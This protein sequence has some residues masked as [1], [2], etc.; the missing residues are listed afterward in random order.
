[1]PETQ[2]QDTVEQDKETATC[3][4]SPD[5]PPS[6]CD[7]GVSPSGK[8]ET[9]PPGIGVPPLDERYIVWLRLLSW[10]LI[11]QESTSPYAST[12]E[13]ALASDD[14]A[15][16]QDAANDD[17]SVA[18]GSVKMV[19]P[20]HCRLAP[21]AFL[22]MVAAGLV[23][24]GLLLLLLL[25]VAAPLL[26]PTATVTIIPRAETLTTATTVTVVTNGSP[27]VA[28][29]QV[30]GRR[31]AALTLSQARIVPTTG[32]GH[33]DA[34]VAHGTLILYNAL[35]T[36]QVIPAGTLL[37]G[38][39][40]V[41]VVTDQNAVIPAGSLS[42]NGWASVPAHAL[43]P[44]PAGNISADDIYGVCCR[45]DVFARNETPFTGGQNA[46]AFP[47]V[48]RQDID[49]AVSTPTTDLA[50]SVQ[51]AF[52]SQLAPDETLVT[53]VPCA[54][55][56]MADHAVGEEETQVTVTL[57]EQCTATA[58]QSRAMQALI[59]Q[60][61]TREASHQLGEDYALEGEIEVRVIAS[62]VKHQRQETIILQV[63]GKGT[64]VYQFTRAQLLR[65]GALIAGASK[66]QAAQTLLQQ[67]GVRTIAISVAGGDSIT[68]PTD[69]KG[70]HMVVLYQAE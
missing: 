49:G 66:A 13:S 50:H 48:T 20:H 54:L 28:R 36:A 7:E 14:A 11:Q 67:P 65:F 62:Q 46:R 22:P 30:A 21:H 56:V 25:S 10:L 8:G 51:A 63:R 33:Q 45:A 64:W 29:H 27:D 12:V 3:T 38:K 39:D 2:R 1:M 35:P 4:P 59:R 60:V 53:P 23:G 24:L 57:G 68:L 5:S 37:T 44:G 70:I 15:R 40:G 16:V 69:P 58:Y 32:R 18:A 52:Q 31:L 6:Q 47:M 19:I 17:E 9:I 26:A 34:S 61:M 55:Q 41:Q 42:T 43:E